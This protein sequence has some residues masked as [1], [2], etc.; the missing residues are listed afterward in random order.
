MEENLVAR[1]ATIPRLL[2]GLPFIT[3]PQYLACYFI[4]VGAL[5]EAAQLHWKVSLL[6]PALFTADYSIA[7]MKLAIVAASRG[8][9]SLMNP[10]YS[11]LFDLKFRENG[12]FDG[13]WALFQPYCIRLLNNI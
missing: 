10:Q 8:D 6:P 5:S 3:S 1:K 7:R 2:N 13:G 9:F 12:E 4:E 11:H